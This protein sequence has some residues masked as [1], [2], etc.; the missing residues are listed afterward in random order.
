MA[1]LFRY[2]G[3]KSKAVTL[4]YDDGV[5][6]DRRFI[7]I[8]SKHGIKGTFNI[9]SGCFG[10]NPGDRR[11]TVEEA[12]ELYIGSGNEVAVHGEKH[13]SLGIIDSAEAVI[14]VIRDREQLED[15]FGTVI[16]G[17]AYANGSYNDK[18][19]S[20]LEN[21]GIEY[22]RTTVSTEKTLMPTD[23]LRLPATCHHNNPKLMEMAQAF[24]EP[25]KSPYFWA[26]QP[27][28]FY[29][30]GHSYE[31]DNNDNW[32][33]IED[34]CRFVG[35]RDDVYY[36]TNGEIYE[37]YKAFNSLRISA[38]GKIIHNPTA[39]DV[40]ACHMGADVLIKPGE[41]VRID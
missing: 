24:L 28:L 17:M 34:F 41:I 25:P 27:R 14:D 5:F 2:P 29:L 15:I 38:N 36:A 3:F 4:S 9:N 20:I 30:W 23:W 11:L 7:E 31:F 6:Q 26:K 33:V 40:Y 37:N 35:G 16:K 22:A 39:Y 10:K 12:R 8:M 1:L 32:N 21:C 19:V 18:V 13:L